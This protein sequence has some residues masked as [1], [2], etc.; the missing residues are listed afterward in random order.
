MGS[1]IAS[2]VV[3]LIFTLPLMA[4]AAE[5]DFEAVITKARERAEAPYKAPPQVPKALRDLAY[6][7]YQGIRFKPE[8]SLWQ[9]QESLFNV[10][11][12]PPGLFYQHPVRMNVINENG[13]QPVVFEK[14]QFT[15]PN[16]EV[17]RLVPAD[18]GYA[19]FKLTFP[20]DGPDVLNQFLVFAGASYFRAVGK[21]NNFGISGRGVAV[22]TGLPSGEEFPSF[23]EFWLQRPAAEDT[24][25][26]FYGLLDGPSLAGAYRF[27]VTPGEETTLK[28]ESALFPRQAVELLGLAPLT[29]MFY[30]GENTLVPHGEWRPEVHDSDGLLIHNGVSGEWLWRPLR[31]PE[32]L[33]IDYFAT[34]NVRGFGL[35]QRDAD[36][37]SYM[38]LEARY[39]S[40]P[41]AW[42]EPEGDWGTGQVVLVQLPTPDETNDN[43]VAFWR[44]DGKVSPEQSL[45]FTYTAK[46]GGADVADETLG[47]VVDTYLGD[48]MRIGGGAEQGAVRVIVDFTGGPLDELTADAPVVSS[49]SGLEGTEVLENSVQ[50]VEPLKRW[51][52]SILARP[53]E[54]RSLALRAYLGQHD[55]TLSETWNYELP[56]RSGVL[57]VLREP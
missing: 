53:A 50:Y 18:L 27:T 35:I 54:N 24:S 4:G 8:S 43:I 36:F 21:D 6:Q 12:V 1:R 49:V 32:A 39:D 45:H 3:P 40:R 30:Y 9:D 29:S 2:V 47:R 44:P 31:A 26:T 10:M 22:N 11:M 13:A 33:S 37:D 57:G 16:G 28:V 7:D 20:F 15:Y 5:F 25:M 46:F 55:E 52:V 14:S 38:D 48:G 19:G 41:S 51:R 56:P 17:E 42:I 34:E 23:V